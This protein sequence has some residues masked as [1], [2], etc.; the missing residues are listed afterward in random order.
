MSRKYWRE[1]PKQLLLFVKR[2]VSLRRNVLKVQLLSELILGNRHSASR[3]LT[4]QPSRLSL[5]R[6]SLVDDLDHSAGAYHAGLD[7][8]STGDFSNGMVDL[9]AIFQKSVAC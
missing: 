5:S 1:I 4:E 2:N 9:S 3:N 8:L 7:C 6:E